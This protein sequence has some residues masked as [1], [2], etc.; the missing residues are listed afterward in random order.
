LL[1]A[2]GLALNR[3]R[4]VPFVA[5]RRIRRVTGGARR[6]HHRSRHRERERRQ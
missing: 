1:E 4:P 2:F 3:R 5:A 6:D